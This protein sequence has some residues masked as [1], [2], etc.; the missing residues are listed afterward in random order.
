MGTIAIK[1]QKSFAEKQEEI[2]NKKNFTTHINAAKNYHI[3]ADRYAEIGD[4]ELSYQSTIKEKEQLR[5]A[6]ETLKESIN[7][8]GLN[9]ESLFIF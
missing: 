3:E 9:S 5:L 6:S 2:T 7:Y 4:R 8:L 1:S